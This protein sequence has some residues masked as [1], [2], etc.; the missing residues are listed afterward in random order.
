MSV[1]AQR[2]AMTA[3]VSLVLRVWVRVSGRCRTLTGIALGIAVVLPQLLRVRL[4]M[5]K[6]VPPVRSIWIGMIRFGLCFTSSVVPKHGGT[7]K[8]SPE[9]VKDLAL[10][11]VLQSESSPSLHLPLSLLLRSLLED[12]N[13]ALSKF[14]EDQTV[15]GFLPVP[16]RRHRRYYRTSSSSFG[17]YTVPPGLAPITLDKVSESRKRPV[18]LSHSLETM[19]SGV[20]EVTSWPDWWLSTCGGFRQH[21]PVEVLG[22]FKRLILSGSRALEFLGNQGVTALG[23]LVLSDRDSFLLDGR[24]TVSAEKVAH[25]RYA[26]LPSSLGIF[27]T[28]L[29]DSTLTKMSTA[30][31][32]ALVQR[33]LHS[34]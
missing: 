14:V 2:L 29:L 9:S 26:D 7:G 19:L 27:P 25:L 13:L 5:T 23:N 30:S 17:P 28:S 24:S 1:I 8:C 33:T 18:S 4:K 20:C 16:S 15:H 21:L 31:N 11:Y 10:I 22:N 3:P 6:I 12:T 32:D 34:P